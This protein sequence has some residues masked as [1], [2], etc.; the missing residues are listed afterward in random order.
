MGG[1]PAVPSS[2]GHP[3]GR[4]FTRITGSFVK[5]LFGSFVLT[6]E[7]VVPSGLLQGLLRYFLHRRCSVRMQ[8]AL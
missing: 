1:I 2:P 3:R 7:G 4:A 8:E 5:L 6:Y